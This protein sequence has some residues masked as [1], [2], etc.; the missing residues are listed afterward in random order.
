M[1]KKRGRPKKKP[2]TRR[3]LS[4]HLKVTEAERDELNA[5]AE[6]AGESFSNWLRNL[7]LKAARKAA[8]G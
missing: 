2:E 4:M 6:A 3:N 5:A 8:R 1:P 7:G